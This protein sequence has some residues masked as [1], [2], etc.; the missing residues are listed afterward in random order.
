MRILHTADWHLGLKTDD[1]DREQEQKDALEEV[2]AIVRKQDIDIV[3]VAGDVYESFVPSSD[4]ENLF[5]NTIMKLSNEGNT[6]VVIIPGNHDEPKRLANSAVF[7]R[8]FNIHIVSNLDPIKVFSKDRWRIKPVNSGRGFIEFAKDNGES[9]VVACMPY[10]SYSRYKEMKKEGERFSDKCKEW[11]SHGASAFRDD[12]INIGISHVYSYGIDLTEEESASFEY[13]SSVFQFVEHSAYPA[14]AHYIALGHIHRCITV[15]KQKHIYYSGSL[16]NNFF[17][18]GDAVTKVIVA[19]ISSSGVQK[20]NKIPLNTKILKKVTVSSVEEAESIA[21]SD[22]NK[23]AL[24]KV[25]IKN[26]V[27]SQ[28]EQI[29]QLRKK[30]NNIVSIQAVSRLVESSRRKIEPKKDLT[31]S[32]LFNKFCM[33]RTGE[34]P[35]EDVL[36]LFLE[37][38]GEVLYETD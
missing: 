24:L 8:N 30:H 13:V 32:E 33:D 7:A 3:L 6:A 38:M 17:D 37:T 22:E 5:F 9:C 15:N 14:K 16:I 26:V 20:V 34:Q 23:G 25:I 28:A 12:T 31:N 35:S 29:K 21:Q 4:A 1:F 11:F 10:P 18:G 36:R 19:D 27:P 2:I